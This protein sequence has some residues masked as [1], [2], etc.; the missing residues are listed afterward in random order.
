MTSTPAAPFRLSASKLKRFLQCPRSYFLRYVQRVEEAVNGK[1]LEV[2][3]AYDLH[4][5]W[6][7][8]SGARG[9]QSID[10][11]ILRMFAA[12]RRFLP[13]PGACEVQHEYR[14]AHPDGFVVE[15]KPDLRRPGWLGDTKT[16]AGREWTL[17]PAT[18]RTNEQALLYAWCEF[19]L[20]PNL[21]RAGLN[22]LY[23]TKTAKPEAWPVDVALTR[24]EAEAWF[25][26][27]ARPAAREMAALEREA[28]A[29]RVMANLDSCERCWTKAHCDPFDGPNSYD[30]VDSGVSLVQLRSRRPATPAVAVEEKFMAFN[31][32]T[33][34]EDTTLVEQLA[35]SLRPDGTPTLTALAVRALQDEPGSPLAEALNPAIDTT[36][37]DV[38]HIQINPPKPRKRVRP[39]PNALYREPESATQV[40]LEDLASELQTC[41][42]QCQTVIAC[43]DRMLAQLRAGGAK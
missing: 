34:K 16:A 4:V 17:T 5:Q 26:R 32:D 31:L 24:V 15:G 11:K 10:P 19:Q 35:A 29:S 2:G 23:V 42:D 28:D 25:D 39:G 38:V 37:E 21:C 27:V 9:C 14:I 12:A 41:V 22:W 33:L 18:L 3:N 40:T 36:D 6:F 20:D 8:S 13:A 1:Y 43:V 30:G 7:L